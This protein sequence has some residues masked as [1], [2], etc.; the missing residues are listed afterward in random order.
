MFP[1]P[2]EVEHARALQAAEAL[3]Q[4]NPAGI[5]T[6]T[7]SLEADIGDGAFAKVVQCT[8]KVSCRALSSLT[9]CN[10]TSSIELCV[11]CTPAYQR[12]NIL[13]FDLL[14]VSRFAV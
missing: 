8:H 12:K 6:D 10:S 4:A 13:L 1:E 2:H 7:Y 14:P 11:V 9:S 5:V 3:L